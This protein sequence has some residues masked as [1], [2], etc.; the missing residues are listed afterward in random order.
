MSLDIALPIVEK[1]LSSGS[2]EYDE[3]A[4]EF[5]GGE[6]FLNF[7]LIKQICE[8]VWS[9]NWKKPYLFFATT[10]GTLIHGDIQ[11]WLTINRHRF[12]ITLSLD[13]TKDMHN[14]NR[15]NS[16]SE[17]DIPFFQRTWQ[18]MSIKMTISKETLPFL[19]DGVIFLHSLGF[20][21]NNNFAFGIDWSDECNV[22]ILKV[23]LEK[24]TKYYLENP[25]INLCSFMDMKIEYQGCEVKKWCGTGTHMASYDVD[26]MSYPCHAF[27]PMSIG[28]EKAKVSLEIDFYSIENLV[29]L[30]CRE[31]ILHPLCPTCYGANYDESGNVFTRNDHLCQLTKIRALACSYLKAK[32]ILGRNGMD[33]LKGEN[34]L[35]AQSALKI[36]NTINFELK[37][38][39]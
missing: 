2:T 16:F 33:R 9:K 17:I 22:D 23:E 12:Y 10:N 1:Y 13:G 30:K 4:I 36:Q 25:E 20:D 7:P 31:C 3:C 15:S 26:G 24:L 11:D 37:K 27:L 21:V 29:D 35:I 32:I 28:T 14:T 39:D 18:D 8:Y 34:Y 38:G 19:A 6:P 5:F